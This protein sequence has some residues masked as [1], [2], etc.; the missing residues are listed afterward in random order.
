MPDFG[1]YSCMLA[2]VYSFRRLSFT[3]SIMFSFMSPSCV[4]YDFQGVCLLNLSDCEIR[5][6]FSFAAFL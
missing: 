3:K 1:V 5:A 2:G 6:V 4:V